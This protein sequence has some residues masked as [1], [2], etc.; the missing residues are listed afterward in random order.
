MHAGEAVSCRAAATI[1]SAVCQ[2]L[3]A[4]LLFQIVGGAKNRKYIAIW[5]QLD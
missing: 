1:T 5:E 4:I 3:S 2:P